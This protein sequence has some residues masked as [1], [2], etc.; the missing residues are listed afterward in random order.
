MCQEEARKGVNIFVRGKLPRYKESQRWPRVQ[1][2]REAMVSKWLKVIGRG[3]VKS[4]AVVSLTGSFAVPKGNSDIRMVYDATKCG[5]NEALW[6]PNFLLPTIDMVVRQAGE[7]SWFGDI[8]LGEQF[9]N[10]PLDESLRPYAGIDITRI[11]DEI[12]EGILTEEQRASKGRVFLRWER[13][14]MGLKSSPYNAQKM[15]AWVCDVIRGDPSHRFNVFRWDTYKSNCPGSP[16]YDPSRPVGCRWRSQDNTMSSSFE[17]YV[18]DVRTSGSSEEECVRASRRVASVCNFYGIQDAA[19]KR[20]FPSCQPSVWCGSRI[21]SNGQ[22]IFAA[23]TQEKWDKGKEIVRRTLEEMGNTESGQID[24]K[25]LERGRGFM[26][27]L[28]RTYPGMVPFLKGMHHTLETWRGGRDEDGWKYGREDWINL[29]MEED[30][31]EGRHWKEVMEAHVVK[32]PEPPN[33][34]TPAA[35]LRGDLLELQRIMSPSKPPNRLLRSLGFKTVIYSFADASGA[36]F[37]STW[38]AKGKT[39]FRVGTWGEDTKGKSSNYREMRNLL[40]TIQNM[41]KDG[42][43]N[44]SEIFLFTDNSTSEA[45]F[46]KGSSKSRLLHEMVG[47]MRAFELSEGCKIIVVHISGKRMQCQGVDGLSRGNMLEGIMQNN[48]VLRYIP[49]HISALN[50]MGG[51]KLLTW[52]KSWMG[53]G[54][55][56]ITLSTEDWFIRA[57]DIVGYKQGVTLLTEPV[58]QQGLFLWS[59][60]PALAEVAC[61][62]LRKAR[63][64][65]QVSTHVFICPRLMSPYWRSHLYRSAD[66]IFEIPPGEYYWPQDNFEPLT[67]ALFFPFLSHNP[68]QLKRTQ[69]FLDMEDVLRRM[70]KERGGAQGALLCK[71][72]AQARRL[73]NLSSRMVRHMLQSLSHFGVSYQ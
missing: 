57:H 43:L 25:T 21:I 29:L 33:K 15:M 11:K 18:D 42:R 56:L 14:L 73:D 55:Q 46:Y 4:G 48:D 45:A 62:E 70:W 64:K 65:R 27:H 38:T 52:I 58:Y 72:W 23:T 50:R 67:V 35:R 16:T 63:N 7:G 6:A 24:R 17:I 31:E 3:Y 32:G 26:I 41:G 37:G 51:E 12:P 69:A 19:R 2:Q 30:L 60:P 5:L 10:F 13:T 59:P 54:E 34:V 8:D 68:W 28:A 61:E 39:M 40:E 53:K 1:E 20:R 49:L 22:G 71:F 44:G 36:G 66:L 9:L 47:K